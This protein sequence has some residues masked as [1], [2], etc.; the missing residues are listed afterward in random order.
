MLGTFTIPIKLHPEVIAQLK[1]EVVPAP[2][3]KEKS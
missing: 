2:P 3:T 1:V